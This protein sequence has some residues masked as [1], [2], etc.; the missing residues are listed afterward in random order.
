MSVI[1]QDLINHLENF[2]PLSLKMAHD[3]TGF[4]IGSH[5]KKV[6]RVL[7]TLDVRPEVVQEAIDKKIDFIFSHHPVMFHQARNL[8]LSDP[9]NQ[10]YADILK[11][12]MTVYAA[13]TNL[14]VTHPGMNDWLAAAMHLTN[15]LPFGAI[16]HDDGTMDPVGCIGELPQAMT[17]MDFAK[18][19]RQEFN[20]TGLRLVSH[21]PDKMIKKVAVVGGD[22]GK[23][24]KQAIAAG[25]DVYVT[26][27]VY[28]HTGHDMLAY[29]L[30]VV[31]PGHH[32]EAI[33]VPKMA[34]EIQK[35]S[36]ENSWDLTVLQSQ[37][38]TDPFTFIF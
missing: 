13:H 22:G 7:V 1:A 30:S 35:W 29:G 24:F 12:D 8:D 27:D 33:M 23:F 18:Q 38:N 11:H 15:V 20:L 21:E 14:D 3:P 19:V 26:G 34:A 31:D 16:A 28:Y 4:Q 9:Q 17:V 37:P 10:M 2:A 36:D 32:V 25:A 5:Q 6:S